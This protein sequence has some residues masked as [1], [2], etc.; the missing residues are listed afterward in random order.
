LNKEITFKKLKNLSFTK[1]A[2]NFQ[3]IAP[4]NNNYSVLIEPNYL[5]INPYEIQNFQV[6][7]K[8]N[9]KNVFNEF[10]FVVR[11]GV[12]NTNLYFLLYFIYQKNK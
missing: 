6:K 12:K 3:V 2:L 8:N 7:L 1:I 9:L 5:E 10:K 4:E 11:V